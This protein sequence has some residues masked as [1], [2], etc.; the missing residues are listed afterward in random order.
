MKVVCAR[1]ADKLIFISSLQTAVQHHGNQTDLQ[2]LFEH[3]IAAMCEA[4]ARRSDEQCE[5]EE[6]SESDSQIKILTRHAGTGVFLG[7]LYTSCGVG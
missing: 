3:D 5:V 1:Q 6:V 7:A 4:S 2:E